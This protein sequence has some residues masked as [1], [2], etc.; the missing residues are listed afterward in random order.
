MWRMT[1]I[2]VMVFCVPVGSY[3]QDTLLK[4]RA[5]K[6]FSASS[7]QLSPKTRIFSFLNRSKF[8][9]TNSYTMG[10]V[11]SGNGSSALGLYVN[12]IRYQASANVQ[13]QL[14]MG[15]ERTLFNSA[16]GLNRS[17][18]PTRVLPG[19]DLMYR[20]NDKFSIYVGVDTGSAYGLN[21]GYLAGFRERDQLFGV[22][23]GPED[24]RD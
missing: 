14:K 4:Q 20:P 10:F 5:A 2:I 17:N 3:G 9:M 7:L 21:G 13:L 15:V 18:G 11:S 24:I 6:P 16:P 1:W 12:T 8:F 19:F 22:E 23:Q